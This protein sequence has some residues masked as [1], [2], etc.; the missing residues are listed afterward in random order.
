MPPFDRCGTHTS[1]ADR[2]RRLAERRVAP[3]SVCPSRRRRVVMVRRALL[4]LTLA[5]ARVLELDAEELEPGRI[6]VLARAEN[7]EKLFS[8]CVCVRRF[9]AHRVLRYLGLS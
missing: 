2:N 3:E 1:R 6:G 8:A 9:G 4:L 5:R 7:M